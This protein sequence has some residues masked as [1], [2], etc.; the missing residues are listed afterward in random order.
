[1]ANTLPDYCEKNKTITLTFG[2]AGEN[3]IGMQIIGTLVRE[4]FLF[5]SSIK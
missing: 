2:D 3:H 4:A 1:M 5:H